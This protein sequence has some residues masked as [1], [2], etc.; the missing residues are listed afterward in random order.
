MSGL[1]REPLTLFI[2]RNSGGRTFRDLLVQGGLKVVLHDDVFPQTAADEDWLPAV[3]ELGYV[4]IT[5]DKATTSLP[6]FIH[7]L[8]RSKTFVFVLYGLNGASPEGKA[9]CVLTAYS[10]IS[11]LVRSNA[12]PGIWRIGRDG[13]GRR[14]DYARVLERMHRSK[15]LQ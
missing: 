14:F 13:E 1:Q 6:L 8:A 5:G 2:D 15:R 9:R 3:G 11:R 7:R 4:A 12:P 10:T